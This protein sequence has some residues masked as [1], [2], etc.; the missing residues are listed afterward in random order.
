MYFHKFNVSF[1]LDCTFSIICTMLV[2]TSQLERSFTSS[3]T[4]RLISPQ[5][6]FWLW[7]STQSRDTPQL[8]L[9]LNPSWLYWFLP[10]IFRKNMGSEFVDNVA[11]F[12]IVGGAIALIVCGV[13]IAKPNLHGLSFI[14]LISFNNQLIKSSSLSTFSILSFFRTS[15]QPGL[16]LQTDCDC[17]VLFLA[18]L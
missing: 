18:A 11:T 5:F 1:L 13:S 12:F 8:F 4:Y 3:P 7:S 9:I 2:P 15:N 17:K 16:I 6:S 10:L 14:K